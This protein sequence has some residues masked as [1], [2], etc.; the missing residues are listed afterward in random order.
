MA[1][2]ALGKR[3]AAKVVETGGNL[4]GQVVRLVY[5][6]PC[7]TFRSKA[8]PKTI[9]DLTPNLLACYGRVAMESETHI[10][11]L[12]EECLTTSVDNTDDI[13]SQVPKDIIRAVIV[14]EAKEV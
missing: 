13:W 1:P 2:K 9:N 3:A 8:Y 5:D 7:I 6:D 12:H 11:I 14:F 10:V 4:I